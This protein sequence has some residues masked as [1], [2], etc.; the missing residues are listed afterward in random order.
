MTLLRGSSRGRQDEKKRER[1][2]ELLKIII[3]LNQLGGPN[4]S[5]DGGKGGKEQC[6]PEQE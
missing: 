3:K 5:V 6:S 2:V 4:L 1:E